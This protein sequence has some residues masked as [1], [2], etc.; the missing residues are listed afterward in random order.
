MAFLCRL[1]PILN[2]S[3]RLSRLRYRH[4]HNHSSANSNKIVDFLYLLKLCRSIKELNPLHALLIVYGL[5]RNELL[6]REFFGSCFHLGVPYLALCAF[7][8]IEKPSL[9]LQNLMIRCLC[10]CGLYDDVLRVYLHCRVS[11][12]SSNDFTFPSVIKACA[13]LG[14]TRTGR[15]IH[16]VV[17]RTGFEKNVVVQ[18][19]LI[20]LYAK[21]GC[22]RNARNVLDKIPEP[23]LVSWNALISGY[24]LNGLDWEA[25]EAFRRFFLMDFKPNVSTFASMI[26]VCARL[27][28]FKIGRS[29][30]GFAVKCGYLGNDFLVPALVS[31]YAGDMDLCSARNL[32]DFM[33]QKNVATWNAMIFAYTQMKMPVEAFVMFRTMLQKGVQPNLITFVSIIPSCENFV[34]NSKSLG[35]SLHAS[36]IRHG[37]GNQ[38]PVSAALLSMY[39]KFGDLGSANY[40]FYHMPNR[41]RLS[42]NALI[43]GYVYNGL[44]ELSLSAF[45]EMQSAGFDADEVSIVSIISA[46]SKLDAFWLG[47]SVHTFTLRNGFES[48]LNVSNAL[49]AFYAG[50]HQLFS[51]FKLFHEMPIR[52]TISW[53]TLISCC[54]HNSEPERTATVLHQMQNE[55]LELD[56]VT[57]ISIL[58]IFTENKKIGQGMAIHCYT[59]KSGFALDISLVNALIS[60]YCNCGDLHA[61]KFLFEDMPEKSSV[62]WN[63]MMTGFRCRGLHKDV[64]ILFGRM[65][66]EGKRPNH[67]TLLNLLPACCNQLQGKSI[68]AFA[69]RTGV[70]QETPFVT[71]L[72][73]MYARF[74]NIRLCRLLFQMGKKEDI[75]L[76]NALMSVHTQM[77]NPRKAIALFPNLL[78]IGLEPDNFT[79]LSLIAACIQLN[80][81]KLADSTMAYSICKGFDKEIA[82]NNA[83]IDLYARCGN[84]STAR[85]LFNRLKEKDDVSWSVMINGHGLNGDGKAA[86]DL[87]Q[88][89]KLS[90]L[91]P[92]R[93]IYSTL[94]SACSHSGLAEEGRRV[95]NS[96]VESGISPGVE[97]YACLVDLLAR[98]GNLREAYDVVKELLPCK[99]STSLLE[100]LLG[101]C[102]IYCNVEL[103][104]KISRTLF[105]LDPENPRAY[106]ML[107]NI[108]AAAG[109]WADAERVRSEIGT[110]RLRKVPAFS[111]FVGDG[112]NQ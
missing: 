46:C 40:I 57:L 2:P 83:L 64:M 66:T 32:F 16:C 102:S 29:L 31:M 3:S 8:R 77:K 27:R 59:V 85:K 6:L 45:S 108:Y 86:F 33:L 35:E 10:H 92:D 93:I 19:A 26:P 4:C 48:N 25:V 42:W 5:E 112:V 24:S 97:H 49:L 72:V 53:N 61:A 71:S 95:F 47:K 67:I 65:L 69:I 28:W 106:V 99:S 70:A 1:L 38:L 105:N 34:F 101:A 87:F 23:D 75:S 52:S 62:S 91:K 20:D 98:T 89:M 56:P 43:S 21:C 96:M 55:G 15:E 110:R 13:A 39:A 81:L 54:V 84:I 82:I 63:A 78:Q 76:W 44:W 11:G 12:C 88:Q 109:R 41:D 104:E 30:H 58:P 36:A 74:D 37:S 7:K 79:V 9:S 73:I 94:L 68:H 80:S 17:L 111:L 14:A 18:T 100:S 22:L 90:G 103:G 50:C 107:H 51:C 60:M